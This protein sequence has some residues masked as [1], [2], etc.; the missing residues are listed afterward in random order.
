MR[1]AA[2]PRKLDLS[3]LEASAGEVATLLRAL[4]NE[5]RLMLLCLLIEEGEVTAGELAGA[6]GLSAS[7]ASQHLAKMR[8]EGLVASR[9][10][11]QSVLYRIADPRTTQLISLLKDLYCS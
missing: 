2:T 5:R 9:R 6:V 4:A 8:D 1:K 3:A 11:A 10:E 7:A